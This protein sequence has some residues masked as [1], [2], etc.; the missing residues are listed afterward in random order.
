[1]RTPIIAANWKMHKTTAESKQ[2]VTEV[3]D[4]IGNMENV[5]IVICP[6]FTAIE[7]LSGCLS[8]TNLL[9]GAQNVHFAEEGPYTGEISPAMLTEL[10]V[11]FVIVGHSER[12]AYFNETDATVNRKVQA[13]LHHRL[14]P[15]VCVGEDLAER[16]A[17]QTFSIVESQ[18][19]LALG[20][21]DASAAEQAVVAYEPIWAIGTGRS[22]SAAN[23][24]EVCRHIRQTIASLFGDTTANKIRIQYGGSVKPETIQDY[25]Q[26]P[27]I[28]GAL[29]GGASL[30]PQSFVGLIRAAI[31]K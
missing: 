15:I 27:D 20:G 18:I 14:V 29:V 23:A 3:R 10:G 1:M 6:P 8:G 7:S 26:Q 19:R 12:R 21:L 31:Q 16:E 25:L 13:A 22:A 24:N 5:T 30:D 17:G 9:L 2:F 4:P 28:D 11:R